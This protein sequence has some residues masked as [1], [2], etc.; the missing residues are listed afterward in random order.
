MQVIYT[1]TKK[2]YAEAELLYYKQ[3]STENK[4]EKWKK[5]NKFFVVS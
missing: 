4:V 1:E 2:K 5:K 3:N